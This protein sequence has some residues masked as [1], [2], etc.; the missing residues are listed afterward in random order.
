DFA[1]LAQPLF[2][3]SNNK[4]LVWTDEC[5]AKFE[6]LKKRL[7]SRPH[8]HLPDL[9]EPFIVTSD[10]S[11]LATGAVLSQVINGE[12]K[13]VDF[14]SRTFSKAEKRYSTIEREATAILWAL[15]KWEHYLLGKQFTVESDHKPLQW[16]LTK[17]RVPAKL[18]RMA[19]KLQEF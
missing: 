11:D 4:K 17:V 16:L 5:N 2:D 15:E 1:E 19:M 6:L 14:M 3:A 8:T 10:A 7:S 18:G 13:I 12:R 9:N